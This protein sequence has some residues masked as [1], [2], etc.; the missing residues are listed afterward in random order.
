MRAAVDITEIVVAEGPHHDNRK[1]PALAAVI[2]PR[3][4]ET[5]SV[6]PLNGLGGTDGEDHDLL[7]GHIADSF[8]GHA[9]VANVWIATRVSRD[10]P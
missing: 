10:T 3:Q 6:T 9:I 1:R 7:A 5:L 2:D 8:F 4:A